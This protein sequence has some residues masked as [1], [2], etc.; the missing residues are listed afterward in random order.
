MAGTAFTLRRD[1]RG[2]WASFTPL[3]GGWTDERISIDVGSSTDGV[4]MIATARPVDDGTEHAPVGP[5]VFALRWFEC[6]ASDAD[7]LVELSE[8]AW[9]A[10]E[11]GT[12][13][14]LIFGLFRVEAPD[15]DVARFLLCTR[16][17]SVSAWE[18]SRADTNSAEFRRRRELTTRSQVSLW[19]L[20]E[21][22]G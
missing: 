18:T 16:Y 22:R 15:T 1:D 5:G 3:I 2:G 9:P 11:A 14:T 20:E 7:E 10:F 4:P 19:R 6:R 13:G 21:D 8:A 17:P 12:P